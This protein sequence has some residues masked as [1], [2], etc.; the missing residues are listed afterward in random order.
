MNQTVFVQNLAF[1]L[2]GFLFVVVVVK[3][4]IFQEVITLIPCHISS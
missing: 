3:K 4:I 1:I 2:C